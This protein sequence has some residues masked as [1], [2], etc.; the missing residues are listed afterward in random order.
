M[1]ADRNRARVVGSPRNAAKKVSHCQDTKAHGEYASEL[2]AGG[3]RKRQEILSPT[4][5]ETNVLDLIRRCSSL[6]IPTLLE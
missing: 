1:D 6:T 5:R 4:V 3:I 2:S